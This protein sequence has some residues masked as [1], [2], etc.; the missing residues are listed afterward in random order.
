MDRLMHPFVSPYSCA[1]EKRMTRIVTFAVG[2]V[3]GV[4]GTLVVQKPKEAVEKLWAVVA[5]ARKKLREAFQ[6]DAQ[7]GEGPPQGAKA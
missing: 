7:E 5:S 4:I 3:A 6:S 2:V 1:R